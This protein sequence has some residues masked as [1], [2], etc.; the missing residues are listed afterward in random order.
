MLV[1]TAPYKTR[2]KKKQKRLT[3]FPTLSPSKGY[4]RERKKADPT[5]SVLIVNKL[6]VLPLSC[7]SA[8]VASAAAGRTEN[9][10]SSRGKNGARDIWD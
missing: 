8:T 10:G 9:S 4:R 7:K 1:T 3:N 6:E 2:E 5:A